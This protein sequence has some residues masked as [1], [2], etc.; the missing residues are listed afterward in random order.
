[1]KSQMFWFNTAEI[2][3]TV[4]FTIN[5]FLYCLVDVYNK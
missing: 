2:T 1:M 5:R 4:M 3:V